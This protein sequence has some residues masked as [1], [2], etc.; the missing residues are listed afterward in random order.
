MIGNITREEYVAMLT[1]A[2]AN[3]EAP[4]AAPVKVEAPKAAAAKVETVKVAPAV[5]AAAE[6]EAA[7]PK[8]EAPVK[9]E[10]PAKEPKPAKEKAP[11]A[12]KAPKVKVNKFA[13][14]IILRVAMLTAKDGAGKCE[15]AVINN[16][17]N[18]EF[19]RSVF[20]SETF[21]VAVAG[22][23]KSFPAAAASI[24]DANGMMD[25]YLKKNGKKYDV[26][27]VKTSILS[28]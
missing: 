18:H 24:D 26:A 23:W 22:H 1:K 2:K 14:A 25:R 5:A 20:Y 12:E 15:A 6:A 8:V 11:K 17:G 10:K 4:A 13:A 7:A 16:D 27:D 19:V 21:G 28:A 3:L 9:A